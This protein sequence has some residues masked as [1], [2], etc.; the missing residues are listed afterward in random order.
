MPPIS[1]TDMLG[2]DGQADN[3][4]GLTQRIWYARKADFLAIQTPTP[5]TTFASVAEITTAHTFKT[6]KCFKVMYCT[7]DKGKLKADVQG[8]MD[9][10]SFKQ[11]VEGFYPGNSADF[12]GFASKGKN[13]QWIVLAEN[14]D[15]SINQIG[16]E[17]FP[18]QL[19]PSY[20]SASNASGTKGYNVKWASM[21]PTN[22]IYNAAVTV[23]PAA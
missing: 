17:M 22:L 15:G 11:E 14:P 12:H 13:D 21:G 20:D 19:I 3:M 2:P 16:T 9:G 23:T 8:D 7:Q 5:S 1:I 6:G 4:G 10:H 18:A